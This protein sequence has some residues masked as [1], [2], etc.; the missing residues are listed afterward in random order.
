MLEALKYFIKWNSKLVYGYTKL[1]WSEDAAVMKLR[2]KKNFNWITGG[3]N[4][5]GN[6][7][8]FRHWINFS[9]VFEEI[10][11]MKIA[12]EVGGHPLSTYAKFSE[13]LIFPAP[14]YDLCVSGG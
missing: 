1:I 13:K 2:N 11:G 9:D 4:K 10:W 7:K 14:W 8:S 3:W 5:R 12:S 6:C